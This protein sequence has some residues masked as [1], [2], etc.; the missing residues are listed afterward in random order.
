MAAF[1]AI[2]GQMNRA[3]FNWIGGIASTILGFWSLLQALDPQ[4]TFASY[5]HKA[6]DH[7][8]IGFWVLIT[9]IFFWV[10]WVFFCRGLGKDELEVAK[11]T[12]DL[13]RN[14]WLA[15]VAILAVLF[16]VKV[17]GA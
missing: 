2:G 12:H 16:E 11:H 8:L 9:P 14:I 6:L 5:N 13:S 10:D 17:T 15:L 3:T 7:F 1:V 4:S